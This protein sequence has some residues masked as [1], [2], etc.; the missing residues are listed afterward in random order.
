MVPSTVRSMVRPSDRS[1]AK[2]PRRNWFSA[3]TAARLASVRATVPRAGGRC[4]RPAG[5]GRRRRRPRA[6]PHGKASPLPPLGRDDG[7]PGLER[8][9]GELVVDD[10]VLTR[11]PGEVPGVGEVIGRD[12]RQG[13][14][15]GYLTER[16]L[17]GSA[18]AP[19]GV[20]ATAEHGAAASFLHGRSVGQEVRD[21]L[22]RGLILEA[23]GDHLA[24]LAHVLDQLVDVP[25][26]ARGALLH[27]RRGLSPFIRPVTMVLV[28]VVALVASMGQSRR[29]IDA[30]QQGF[31]QRGRAESG[32]G[33]AFAAVGRCPRSGWVR[34]RP[35]PA[36]RFGCGPPASPRD[37]DLAVTDLAGAG[38]RDGLGHRLDVS[39]STM[40][41]TPSSG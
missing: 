39:S 13:H 19:S 24:A 1:G 21:L 15:A 17:V 9:G 2:L 28:C 4:N 35:S 32:V 41:S 27:D 26:V 11:G 18:P 12:D 37:P 23:T 29:P 5:R 22:G 36:R 40:T 25:L 8:P 7:L 33:C 6:R 10:D 20:A 16:H 3:A 30:P 31:G 14:L 38:R 34:W